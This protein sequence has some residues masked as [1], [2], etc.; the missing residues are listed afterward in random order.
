MIAR[1]GARAFQQVDVFTTR[2][3][4]GNALAVVLD[5][6]GVDAATMQ[7]FAA[8]MNLSES[9]FVLAPTTNDADVRVRIFTPRQELP[10]AG[11]P[12]VGAIH[13]LVQAGRMAGTSIRLECAAGMLPVRIEHGDGGPLV[14]VRSPR[15]KF[16]SVTTEDIAALAS[17]LGAEPIRTAPPRIVDVG[18]VWTIVDLG[19][20][21]TVRALAPDL[22]RVAAF[23]HAHR[24]IG[25]A[26]FGRESSDDIAIAVRAFCPADGIPEDPVTGS[27]NAAIGAFL[28]E[29]GGLAA[30]GA[31][32]IAS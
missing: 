2:A 9:V 16:D 12:T 32:Y 29:T 11:H 23:T 25:I 10:F 15:A 7:R 4:Y 1:G 24:V 14:I 28:R 6:D 22:D 18:A 20:A 27:A 30:I 26:A 31:R 13:A 21:A 5:G 3:G 8:W 19:D 17:A